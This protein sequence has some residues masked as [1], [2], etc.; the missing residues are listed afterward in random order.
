MFAVYVKNLHVHDTTR[1]TKP[2]LILYEYILLQIDDL[3]HEHYV[4]M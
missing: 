1:C 2:T 3:M 4:H